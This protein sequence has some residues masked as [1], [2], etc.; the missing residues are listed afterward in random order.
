ME[1]GGGGDKREKTQE[2]SI[3]M[4]LKAR[5]KERKKRDPIKEG[6]DYLEREKNAHTQREQRR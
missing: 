6:Q 4:L 2:L 1:G 3:E 5:L